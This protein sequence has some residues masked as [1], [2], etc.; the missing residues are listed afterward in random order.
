MKGSVSRGG[1]DDGIASRTLEASKKV[2]GV[3]P[4]SDH[5]M[6]FAFP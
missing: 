5:R 1:G 3:S 2:A 4:K 6:E